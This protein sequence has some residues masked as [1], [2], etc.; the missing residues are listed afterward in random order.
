MALDDG[1]R[2]ISQFS[3]FRSVEPEALR[4]LAFSA[5]TKLLRAGDVLIRA[6]IKLNGGWLLTAGSLA[7]FANT[8]QTGMPKQIVKA[9]ALVGEL[10]LITEI[11]FEGSIIA[12]EPSAALFLSRTTFHRVLI[13][14]PKSADAIRTALLH[15]LT[16]LSKSLTPLASD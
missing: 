8:D 2:L 15:R 16:T 4:L 13:E 14:Y 6:P 12:R 5:E 3:L 1:I 10:A 7:R 11:N 9:P